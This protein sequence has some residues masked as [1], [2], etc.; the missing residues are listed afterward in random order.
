MPLVQ[1]RRGTAAQLAAINETPLEG[2]IYFETDTNKVKVG[3]GVR[4]YNS[5]PYLS[6]STSIADLDG[7]Q[8]ALDANAA[9]A[10]A[11]QS[12]TDG[13]SSQFAQH[14]SRHAT[15]GT[16]P[17]SPADIGAAPD[18]LVGE[19]N[20]LESELFLARLDLNNV[21]NISSQNSVDIGN[22]A[23]K[24]ANNTFVGTQNF[25]NSVSFVPYAISLQ[26]I[27]YGGASNGQFL[28]WNGT[29]WVPDAITPASIGAQP[30]GT[31]ATLVG[32]TV[33]ASQLPSYVDDVIEASAL[34]SFPANGETGK[35]YVDLSTN[36]TYRWSGSAYIE[37][38]SSPGSTDAVPE[39]S[40]N[41][42]FTDARAQNALTLSLAAK[43]DTAGDSFTGT[44]TFPAQIITAAGV[45]INQFGVGI[46]ASP[47]ASGPL[48]VR[49][50]IDN[51]DP[52]NPG[53]RITTNEVR[54]RGADRSIYAT[55]QGMRFNAGDFY[56]YEYATNTEWF[57]IDSSGITTNRFLTTTNAISL[58]SGGV[59]SCAIQFSGDPNT[60]IVRN[61]ADTLSLVAGGGNRLTVNTSGCTLGGTVTVSSGLNV[62]ELAQS[63]ASTN[64]VLTWNGSAWVP[65][66]PS[67]GGGSTTLAAL[68]D[69]TIAS[70]AVNQVLY[71]GP[72]GWVNSSLNT[73][74]I[75]E[76]GNLYHTTARAEAAARGIVG[77]TANTLCAG[78][79]ARLSDARTPTAHTHAQSDITG[80]V[81][82]LASKVDTSDARLSDARTPTAH[83]HP[84]SD[85]TNLV[86]DLSNKVDTTDAR[87]SDARTPTA[88][89][90]SQSD[91]TG[92]TTDLANKVDTTDARLSDARTPL[93]HVHAQSDITNL[94]TDLAGKASA[95][96]TH[97]L[98]DL[99]NFTEVGNLGPVIRTGSGQGPYYTDVSYATFANN[100]SVGDLSN[101]SASSPSTGDV[102]KFNGSTWASSPG[103]TSDTTQAGGGTAVNN[104]VVISQAAYTALGT[105]D[106]NTIYFIT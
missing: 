105:K 66:A 24:V 35:I 98:A 2:Q 75:A 7:L 71:Y 33:P 103:V 9:A 15:T 86:T 13:L 40:N 67:G 37:I 57:R 70:P 25:T 27:D 42:Y 61:A 38:A 76:S 16:D 79:D 80:L 14:K 96:H 85:V 10:A 6:E 26:S 69:V 82:D 81:S 68:T 59:T 48:T 17:L 19:V 102:L 100:I 44:V 62:S 1:Q 58:P 65:T 5:L 87:L 93:A 39:G 97:A 99:S 53:G 12:S 88:H 29:T 92:L 51:Y 20:T 50:N 45:Y 77:T 36:K 28:K 101:V 106:A 52:S 32:G 72:S 56:F 91:I 60:G 89:T 95:G 73:G 83:T 90:H 43:A 8:A 41:L 49:G 84:Q 63:G 11:A 54:I 47:T 78:D 3:D 55:A 22:K 94:V 30:A 4:A 18:S 104:I 31:Y 46:G 74:V 23:D 21:I 34:A 64:D